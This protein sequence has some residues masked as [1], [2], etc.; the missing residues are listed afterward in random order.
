MGM[1]GWVAFSCF[2]ALVVMVAFSASFCRTLSEGLW[3]LAVYA[4]ARAA[5]I[6]SGRAS[7]DRVVHRAEDLVRKERDAVPA[8]IPRR[9]IEVAPAEAV[10]A[11]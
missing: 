1:T 9:E 8:A 6:E 3:W 7:F 2:G 10:I 4:R 11:L 5:Q